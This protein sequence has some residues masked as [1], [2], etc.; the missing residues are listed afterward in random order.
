LTAAAAWNRWY[1]G[2]AWAV[3][4][5]PAVAGSYV[6][7]KPRRGRQTAYRIAVAVAPA[8]LVL[9]LTFGPLAALRLEWTIAAEDAGAVV[10]GRVAAAGPLA[11][12]L[13]GGMA[14]RAAAAMPGNL[15]RLAGLA[16][17][18]KTRPETG[19]ADE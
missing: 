13:V 11:G 9:E 5:G 10:T 19:R 4:E 2:L 6:T 7:L 3:F 8:C 14:R 16:G 18:K 15:E 12:L 1:D 17:E